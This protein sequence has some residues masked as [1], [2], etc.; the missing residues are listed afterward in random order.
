MV[1]LVGILMSI[2]S[3]SGQ[4]PL[5][6]DTDGDGMP[7]G[8]EVEHGLNPNN[9]GD[10]SL[11]YN[12]NGLSN[13][14]EYKEDYDPWDRDTDEDGLSNYAETTGLFGFFTDPL[15]EDT[16]DD[17]LDDLEEICININT[18]NET[19]MW[20]LYP[21]DADRAAVK[22]KIASIREKYHYKLNPTNSDTDYDGLNDG[23]EISN[24]ANPT[25]VDSDGDGLRD[26]DEV[27]VYQTDPALRDTDGDGLTDAEEIFG[28]YG[29]VTDPT[30]EDT[31]GDGI[32][33]GEECLSFGFV[34]IAPSR[35][36][37]S[38]EDFI[39]ENG[40]VNES[41][42]LKAR[43][44]TIKYGVGQTN[45]TIY[46][47]SLESDMIGGR[48]GVAIVK[49]SWHYDLEYG[50]MHVDDRFKLCLYEGDTIVIVGT[51]KRTEGSTREIMVESG[52]K[53]YLVLSPEEA[54][55]RWLPS[56]EYVK[57][58]S[59]QKDTTPLPSP[60]PT[61]TLTP[62]SSP[63]STSTSSLGDANETTAPTPAPTPSPTPNPAPTPTPGPMDNLK[64]SVSGL[65]GY[66]AFGLIIVVIAFFLYTKV[67]RQVGKRRK[68]KKKQKDTGG[69]DDAPLPEMPAIRET[70]TK[71]EWS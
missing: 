18:G 17:G 15:A 44:D 27:Y 50:M 42:T 9:A 36:A 61:P 7:D 48:R 1:V 30:E 14:Q 62:E 49:S 10:A 46:L 35:Y 33:D 39:S 4:H 16:D 22:D 60:T 3:V 63:P 66:G 37:V 23:A 26:G 2:A 71:K 12:D 20:E 57:I 31:D 53:L 38:Y 51:A 8:W 13:F 67:G 6:A 52:G 5:R 25:S 11:D 45:Y 34:P 19:H 32:S 54:R 69:S 41:I 40:Y 58:F 28:S 56:N 68:D 70:G 43:V 47:K 24:E 65:L 64:K 21:N 55:K 59:K 29:F